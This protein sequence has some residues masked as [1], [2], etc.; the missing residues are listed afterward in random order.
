MSVPPDIEVWALGP[1][2]LCRRVDFNA[3]Q[4]HVTIEPCSSNHKKTLLVATRPLY[5]IHYSHN[6]NK[7]SGRK[8]PRGQNFGHL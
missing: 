8:T 5:T 2:L 1:L 7:N 3:P 4:S 6:V